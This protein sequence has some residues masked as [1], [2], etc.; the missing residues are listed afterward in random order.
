M[1]NN[2]RLVCEE[3]II[4]IEGLFD[5]WKETSVVQCEVTEI[6]IA[7]SSIVGISYPLADGCP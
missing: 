3:T 4:A 2:N 5:I 7:V 1:K 6:T